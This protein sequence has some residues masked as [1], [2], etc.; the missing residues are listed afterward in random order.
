[1]SDRFQLTDL[2]PPWLNL[3]TD[4]FVVTASRIFIILLSDSFP[5]MYRIM[6]G[7]CVLSFY[8]ANLLNSFISS[9]FLMEYLGFSM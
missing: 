2:L 7:F 3:L 8:S 4:I 6:T 9:K 5:L 1:M